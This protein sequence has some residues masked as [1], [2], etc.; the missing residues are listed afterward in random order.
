MTESAK[1]ELLRRDAEWSALASE[2]SD[3][4]GILAYWTEDA[5]V[6]PPGFPAIVGKA[7]LREYIASSLKIPGFR[8]TWSSTDVSFSRD[9]TLAYMFSDNAVTMNGPDGTPV[10]MEGRAVTIWRRETDGTWLCAVDI[11]NSM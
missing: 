6:V 8:I 7:A 11:W 5:V 4:E 1:T 2:G 10:T 9:G 3:I